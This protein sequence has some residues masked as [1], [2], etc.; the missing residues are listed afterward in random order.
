MTADTIREA[1]SRIA[2]YVSTIDESL[3]T[4]VTTTGDPYRVL[5]SCVLS[6]R[7][8]EEVTF[9]AS[10]RLFD[11]ASTPDRMIA[12]SE[13]E[14]GSLIYPVGFWRTKARHIRRLS[15]QLIDD[16]DGQV[17]STMER[18]L[19]LPGVGRKTA[20][21]VL[22][23]GFGIPAI[24]VDTHVHRIMNRIGFVSTATP[25]KTEYALRSTLPHSL[26]LSVNYLLVLFGRNVCTPQSPRC[27]V[28]PVSDLCAQVG[29]LRSR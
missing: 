22:S 23:D 24:C 5:V 28:C 13:E 26:W 19:S 2:S 25:E 15:L 29:V 4:D 7:T 14:I 10:Q 20:N 11:R 9:V 16:H 21:L 6:Q 1:L 8:K 27:S 18:L 17:P 12:L 3:A